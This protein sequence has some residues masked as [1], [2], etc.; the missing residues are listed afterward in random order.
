MSR[1]R[2]GRV[3]TPLTVVY[4]R[5]PAAMRLGYAISK[6]TENGITLD[7]GLRLL[8]QTYVAKLNRCAFCVD[9]AR[10][11]ALRGRV[12]VAQLDALDAFEESDL[13]SPADRAA[14]RYAKE[15]TLHKHVPDDVFAAMREHFNEQQIVEVTLLIAI[16]HYYNLTNIPL[17]IESD[18]LCALVPPELRAGAA[19]SHESD[20]RPTATA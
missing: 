20:A 10:A 4:S 6:F 5:V 16:E 8:V 19:T 2:L 17:E 12:G 3:M 7:P 1:R 14:L 11:L 9:I 18:G 13:F 15:A